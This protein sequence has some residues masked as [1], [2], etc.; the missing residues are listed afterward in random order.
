MTGTCTLLLIRLPDPLP[1]Q[2]R[3]RQ[4]SLHFAVNATPAAY[5]NGAGNTGRE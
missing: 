1:R 2:L 3:A 5:G 4:N